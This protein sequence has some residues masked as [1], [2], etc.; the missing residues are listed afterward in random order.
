MQWNLGPAG[1]GLLALVSLAFGLLAQLV[2]GRMTSPQ[3]WV[4]AGLGSFV[5]GL[6]V[7]EV[8]FGWATG[9]ELQPNIDGLS[10]DEA[11]LGGAI[12]GLASVLATWY[13][14]RTR[15]PSTVWKEQ[16]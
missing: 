13:V 1:L 6:F 14:A 4:I 8:M 7:S 11:L 5:A 10:F 12:G 15:S 16:S 3:L 9:A 2:A